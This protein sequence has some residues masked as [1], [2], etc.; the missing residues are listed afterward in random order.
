MQC[1]P[2]EEPK[3]EKNSNNLIANV[4][5]PALCKMHHL[6]H[7]GTKLSTLQEESKK[8]KKKDKDREKEHDRTEKDRSEK[9]K[10]RSE[11]DRD[12][13]NGRDKGREAGPL[14]VPQDHR[15]APSST[16]VTPDPGAYP[17]VTL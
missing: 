4:R 2:Q 3:K 1:A 10:D 17:R 9:D 16:A 11:R 13:P 5:V 12:R 15:Q 6:R 7:L 14:P 8:E